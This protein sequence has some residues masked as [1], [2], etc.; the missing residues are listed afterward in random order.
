MTNSSIK[1]PVWFWIISVLGLVWNGMG[2]DQYL[3]QAYNTD[4]WQ[5]LMTPEQIELAQ[6]LPSWYTA[7][8]ALAVFGG[9][10]GCVAL[11]LRK[12]WAYLLFFLSLITVLAQMSYIMFVLKMANAMTPIIIIVALFLLYFSKK[13]IAKGWIY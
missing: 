12:K 13:S 9:A 1:P 10:L 7:C 3:G 4:R 5:S 11:L 8:F 2:I 6:N